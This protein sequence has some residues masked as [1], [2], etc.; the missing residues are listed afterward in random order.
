[1]PSA[2]DHRLTQLL[3]QAHEGSN[4]AASE[5]LTLVYAELRNVAAQRL[6]RSGAE[7]TLQPTAL[8]HEAWLRL[9]GARSP[10]WEN[11]RHFFSAA[12]RAMRDIL[13]DRARASTSL[14]RGGG[15]QRVELDESQLVSSEKPEH[16][17]ALDEALQRLE[18]VSPEA[19]RVVMLRVFAGLTVTETAAALQT[20]GSGVDRQ[21]AWAKAWLQRAVSDAGGY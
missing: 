17:L 14:K 20:S 4:D 2:S 1:M 3:D 13:V 7:R 16:I 5:L 6:A 18:Q 8:V 9:M 11:R 15:R 19:A 12:A 21:W 10:R